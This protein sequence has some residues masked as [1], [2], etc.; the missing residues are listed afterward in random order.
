MPATSPDSLQ[1][2]LR[3]LGLGLHRVNDYFVVRVP[4][5][6]DAQTV[7][8][9]LIVCQIADNAGQLV[10]PSDHQVWWQ[11]DAPR[12]ADGQAIPNIGLQQ[13]NQ[14]MWEID[15]QAFSAQWRLSMKYSGKQDYPD[16]A[17]KIQN[18]VDIINREAQLIDPD[19]SAYRNTVWEPDRV[20]TPLHRYRDCG[21]S[22]AG[23][24]AARD[25]IRRMKRIA[26]IGIGGTGAYILDAVSKTHVAEI[27]LFDGKRFDAHNAF[28]APG[29]ATL[30]QVQDGHYKVDYFSALYGEMHMNLHPH[31]EFV[32]SANVHLLEGFDFAFVAVDRAGARRCITEYLRALQIPFIDVGMD[33]GTTRGAAVNGIVRATFCAPGRDAHFTSGNVPLVDPPDN[34][35]YASNI[36]VQE[37]NALNANLAVIKW[38]QYAGFYANVL[39]PDHLIFHIESLSLEHRNS[40]AQLVEVHE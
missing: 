34:G 37:I 22:N 4:A 2:E 9:G 39:S 11:G 19:A 10:P 14:L 17:A 6:N 36:Q 12:L 33:L 28:R 13:V 24:V 20:D 30:Q 3:R 26:I 23:I 16:L 15:G 8:E 31:A 21:P 5:V 40:A 38:K 29:A 1:D 25:R 32:T 7:R 35:L 27:H 18:Y